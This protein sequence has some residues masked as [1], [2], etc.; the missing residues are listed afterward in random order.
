MKTQIISTK[1]EY[2]TEILQMLIRSDLYT[3]GLVR[4]MLLESERKKAE[5]KG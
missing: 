5:G 4:E 2:V 1:S 3:I